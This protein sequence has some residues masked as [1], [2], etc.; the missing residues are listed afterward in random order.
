MKLCAELQ[1]PSVHETERQST[2]VFPLGT[3]T[4]TTKDLIPPETFS[5]DTFSFLAES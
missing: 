2:S 4:H 5:S 1:F 3:G